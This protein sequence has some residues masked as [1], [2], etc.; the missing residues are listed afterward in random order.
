MYCGSQDDALFVKDVA[1]KRGEFDF[2]VDDGSRR[3]Q[4]IISSFK[5]LAKYVKDGGLYI[6]E[7][8]HACCWQGFR[9]ESGSLNALS[10]FLSLAHSLNVQAVRH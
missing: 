1:A 6:V 7:D 8:V 5:S 9:G 4:H 2:I 10:C 3:S